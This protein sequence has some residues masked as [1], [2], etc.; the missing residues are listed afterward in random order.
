MKEFKVE[1]AEYNKTTKKY[2]EEFDSESVEAE[3]EPEAIELIKQY[4]FDNTDHE[5]YPEMKITEDGIEF[6]NFEYCCFRA[7]EL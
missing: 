1:W 4:I 3:S 2:K 7:K 5:E 6:K